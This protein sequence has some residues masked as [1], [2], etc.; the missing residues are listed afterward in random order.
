M[1]GLSH[2]DRTRAEQPINWYYFPSVRLRVTRHLGQ[3][4]RLSLYCVEFYANGLIVQWNR[5]IDDLRTRDQLLDEGYDLKSNIE[6]SRA[7][8][9]FGDRLSLDIHFY[10]VCWDKI[11]KYLKRFVESESDNECIKQ[12]WNN[13]NRLTRK[14]SLA[15]NLFEHLHENISETNY[16]RTR[17]SFTNYEKFLF[18]YIDVSNKGEKFTRDVT[19]G[20]PEVEKAMLSYE[21]ILSCL[22]ADVSGGYS[23]SVIGE[24]SD[25]G[26]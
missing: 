10:L 15:R 9:Q 20:K 24:K 3:V 16:G 4:S 8:A 2:V 22:G 12:I 25:S 26:S 7:F 11:N 13:I 19:L 6:A 5:I 1:K 21:G 17:Y 23:R 14:A 18:R